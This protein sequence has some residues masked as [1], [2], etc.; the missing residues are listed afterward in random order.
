MSEEPTYADRIFSGLGGLLDGAK[1]IAGDILEYRLLSQEIEA[2]QAGVNTT[3]QAPAFNNTA[4][5]EGASL[6][7]M[8]QNTL[9]Y[10]AVGL[11]AI[12]TL[13][14]FIRG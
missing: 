9:V 4:P 11:S 8:D 1:S 7:N 10:A 6:M 5:A 13:F 14:V 2:Q 12:A 3:S